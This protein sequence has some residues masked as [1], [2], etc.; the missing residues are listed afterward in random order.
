M[1]RLDLDAHKANAKDLKMIVD[2]T[3]KVF[4]RSKPFPKNSRLNKALFKILS[5]SIPAAKSELDNDYHEL[6]TDEQFKE[7]G[8]IYYG[9]PK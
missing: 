4:E 9:G 1:S 3:R 2:L 6:I 7:L 5:H 8:H